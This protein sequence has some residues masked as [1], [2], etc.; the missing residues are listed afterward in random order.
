MGAFLKRLLRHLP[1]VLGVVLFAG[2][3]YVVQREFRDL[4]VVDI[5]RA[6]AALPTS[7][8]VISFL[9]TLLAY[10]IL[11]FYDRLATAYAGEKVSYGKVAF[12]SFCAYTLAHN[13]G[14]AAV[15][16]AAVRYRLYAHWGLTPL[17][18]GK[19]IVFCS[20]T[21]GFGGLVL[22]GGILFLEPDAI[23][24]LGTRLPNW[25]MYMI[26]GVMW[27]VVTAYATLSRVLG[28]VR[29]FGQVVELPGLRLALL[30]IILATVDVAVTASI[31]YAL[32]P[33]VPGLTYP[34][35]L[36]IYLASY[37]AGLVANLPGGLGV[38]DTAML[39]G[40][41][42]YMEAPE[43]VGAILVFRLYYYII[44]LF[45]AGF[46]FAGN[47]M[48]MRGKGV[49]GRAGTTRGVQAIGRWSQPDFAVAAATGAVAL[50]G[51]LLM[52][53]GLLSDIGAGWANSSFWIVGTMSAFVPSLLGA[54]LLLLA[55]SL[56][57]R[58]KLAWRAAIALLLAGA[59][60]VA[61]HAGPLWIPLTLLAAA[62]VLAPFGRAFYRDTSLFSGRLRAGTATPLAAL[63]VCVGVLASLEPKL[64]WRGHNSFWEV[65]L[66]PDVPNGLRAS[67]ALFLAFA[68]FAL[69][70][71]LRPARVKAAPWDAA[72]RARYAALSQTSPPEGVEGIDGVDGVVWG[73]GGRAAIVFRR[74][75]HI[76]LALGDPAGDRA[77]RVSA[78]WRLRD[79]ARQTNATPAIWWAGR[80]L[81][82]VY[83]DIGLAALPL[84]PDGALGADA[85][86]APG[87]HAT[88]YLVCIAERDLPTLLPILPSLARG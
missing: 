57:Q 47:E 16:G 58:V 85:E 39:L 20:L 55:A 48:L 14:F 30:Q 68:L 75:G 65:I 22:G 26:G 50:C 15:S 2:A 23:P 66:A 61:L 17:Q 87:P 69:W 18:I 88:H 70:R 32:L 86:D 52:S 34:R 37:T 3:I 42:P 6:I 4:K 76:L 11:T 71:L 35:F 12:A 67:L 5:Q 44:P 46:L 28:T 49:L 80:D 64:A 60:F 63:I 21:F 13:L 78:I 10:G 79:L 27:A 54:A 59:A 24:L 62:A 40:L 72:A 83:G 81:L 31:F 77:D 74:I 7:A 1:P 51:A 36:G 9:W 56:A 53:V 84:K 41:A 45:L 43:I 33:D 82:Q 8:L 25:V 73:E 29:V 38:F 19:V